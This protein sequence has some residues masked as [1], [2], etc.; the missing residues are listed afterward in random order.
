[1]SIEG[2]S[3]SGSG[4]QQGQG[5][6]GQ[7]Q[8]EQNGRTPPQEAIDAC[9]GLTQGTACSINTPNGVVSGTCGTPPNSSQLACMPAGGP[10]SP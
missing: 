9:T 4:Q 2:A 10:P 8:G 3:I 6:Q 7:G 5:Q 1:M